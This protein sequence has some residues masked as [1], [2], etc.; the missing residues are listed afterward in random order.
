MVGHEAVGLTRDTYL[1]PRPRACP[2]AMEGTLY[3][4]C[5]ADVHGT[6]VAERCE[7]CPRAQTDESFLLG[8]DI[9][10]G[11]GRQPERP[12]PLKRL[13]GG[14]WYLVLDDDYDTGGVWIRRWRW[15]RRARL[16]PNEHVYARWVKS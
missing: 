4:A 16:R 11:A 13:R 3:V 7:H 9:H 8:P 15:L 12:G 10:V 2:Y 1:H 6:A 14:E 5:P